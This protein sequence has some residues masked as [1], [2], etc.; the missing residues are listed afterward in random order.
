MSALSFAIRAAHFSNGQRVCACHETRHLKQHSPRIA[1]GVPTLTDR[2]I[3]A[4]S[5]SL[6]WLHSYGAMFALRNRG[7]DDAVVELGRA[8]VEDESR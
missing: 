1:I 2:R 8:L 5:S 3:A 6:R 4:V 7:G